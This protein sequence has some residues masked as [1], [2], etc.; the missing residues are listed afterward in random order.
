MKERRCMA[1]GFF[2]GMHVMIFH[3]QK[4][5]S[6]PHLNALA[7]STVPGELWHQS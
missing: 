2:V 3:F 1:W 7:F 5:S 4:F 6:S